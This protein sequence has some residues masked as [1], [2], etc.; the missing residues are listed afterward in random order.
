MTLTTGASSTAASGPV[1]AGSA[2]T[3]PHLSPRDDGLSTP[4]NSDAAGRVWSGVD[5]TGPRRYDRRTMGRSR[6]RARSGLYTS[7]SLW[8]SRHAEASS[9]AAIPD[10][11]SPAPRRGAP[12]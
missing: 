4:T 12:C 3:P 1:P 6:R 5:T 8:R 10:R 9:V 11:C 7:S 2:F